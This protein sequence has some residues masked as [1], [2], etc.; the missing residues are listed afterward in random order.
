[1]GDSAGG[2]LSL[3]LVMYLRDA[4]YQNLLPRAMVL[5]SPWVDLTMSCGSWDENAEF[6]VVPIP[7]QEGGFAP[8][9]RSGISW[10]DDANGSHPTTDH[11][12]P[13]SCYLGPEGIKKYLT[14]PYASPLFGDFTGL[15]PM[16]MQA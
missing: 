7:G 5:M 11:L 14:H 6:D 15:P 13:V 3:A 12:N 10:A 4:G 9:I 2:G 16:L 8:K 1:M